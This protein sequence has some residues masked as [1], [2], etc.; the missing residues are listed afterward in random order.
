MNKSATVLLVD[1]EQFI[2]SILARIVARAG[3]DHSEAANGV[4]ALEA[5]RA[6]RYDYVI[7]D[8]RMPKMDGI[9]LLKEIKLHWPDTRVILI[10]AYAGRHGHEEAVAA[11]AD[12]YISK[13]FR[14]DE[15][16]SSLDA[17]QCADEQPVREN[18]AEMSPLT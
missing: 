9:D 12:G 2:R 1:D 7:A 6:T 4:A 13:P 8:I 3:Y 14:T 11:G 17:L 10:T 15:I 16:V 5:L 18:H